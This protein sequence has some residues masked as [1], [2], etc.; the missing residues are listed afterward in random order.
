MH[1]LSD[2]LEPIL[3]YYQNKHWRTLTTPAVRAGGKS[4]CNAVAEIPIEVKGEYQ[5]F[6]VILPV[7][8]YFMNLLYSPHFGCGGSEIKNV[9]TP[10]FGKQSTL[11]VSNGG[12]P[13]ASS[14]RGERIATASSLLNQMFVSLDPAF[15]I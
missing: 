14:Y 10:Y 3:L 13:A 11:S 9:G 12:K 8:Q 5:P 2:L 6:C 1:A 7:T 15:P 4:S